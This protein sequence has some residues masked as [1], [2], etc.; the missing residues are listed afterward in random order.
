MEPPT[1]SLSDL[2]TGLDDPHLDRDLDRAESLAVSLENTYRRRVSSLTSTELRALLLDY[3]SALENTYKPVM[4]ARL[5][6]ATQDR[7]E[8]RRLSAHCTERSTAITNRLRFIDLEL[9]RAEDPTVHTWLNALSLENYR[10]FL[11]RTHA[12]SPYALS[13]ET[14]SVIATKD[15][16]GRNAWVDLYDQRTTAWRFEVTAHGSQKPLSLSALRDLRQS[17]DRDLRLA[18][19]RALNDTLATEAELFA[20]IFNAVF[21]DH[22]HTVSLRGYH[23]PEA[24]TLLDDE[25]PIETLDTLMTAVERHYPV[26]QEYLRMK[27]RAL[28]LDRLAPCDVSAPWPTPER[29]FDWALSRSLV[30]QAFG[31]LSNDFSDRARDFFDRRHIDALPR[32]EKR[33]GAFCSGLLPGLSPRVFT[34][35]HG[36]LR[37]VFTLAH[38]LGHGVHFSLAGEKQSLLNYWPT[39]PM[40]ETASVFAESVLARSLLDTERD[41]ALR[42]ALLAQRI[43]EALG[44]IHRQIAFTRWEREIHSLRAQGPVSADSMGSLW[45]KTLRDLYGSTV[46]LGPDDRWGWVAIAHFV[47]YR[48]YCYSYAFGQLLV[49]ALYAQWE[50]DPTEFFPRYLELLSRGGSDSPAALVTAL[51]I[52]ITDPGFWSRGLDVITQWITDFGHTP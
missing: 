38:E 26:G 5:V 9:G 17:P 10:H 3:E 50:R 42:R 22:S 45:L 30:T 6:Q 4:F 27:A 1:W 43:E 35:H 34:N 52:D 46:S 41:P 49:L 44:T 7:T 16:S 12:Q 31:S 40:A 32:D 15:L 14:E 33:D 39:S 48:F 37:D 29:H 36:R 28:G 21:L 23:S 20:T 8:V 18:A 47:H 25:L 11:Q 2:Y 51:G 13:A 24:P 19:Q